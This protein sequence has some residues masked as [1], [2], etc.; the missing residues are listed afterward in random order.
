MSGSAQFLG[1]KLVSWSSKKQRSTAISTTEAE[2][3][4]MSGCCAQ[5]LWMRSH[6]TDYGF[7]FN[8]IPLY[9][10]NHEVEK[11]GVEL[12]FMTTD[13]QVADIFTKALPKERF[14]FLLPQLDTMADVN[15][16]EYAPAKQSHVV[17]PPTR[18]DDQILLSSNWVLIVKM[19][20]WHPLRFSLSTFGSFGTTCALTH[21]LGCTVVSWMR[22]GSIST[23]MFSKMLSI[24]LPPTN[25]NNPFVA[26]HLS[27]TV[28]EYVNT[29]GYPDTL[30]NVSVNDLYQPWRAI[31]SM[32]NM[33]NLATASRGKKK[34]THLLIPSIRF[35]G[36]DGREIFGMPIP[37]ALLTD[38]IKGAPYYDEYQEHEPAQPVVIKEPDSGRIQPLPDVQVKGKEKVF[39]E[40]AAHDLLTLQTPKNKSLVDQFIFQRRTPMPT[41]AFGP[42]ESPSLNAELALTDSEIEFDDVVPK[43]NTEDQDEGQTGPNPGIQD[44]GHAEPNPGVQDE[45]QAGSNHDL[46]ATDAS[47]LQNP[48][49]MDEEF[50]ITAYLNVQ[51]NLKLPFE[52]QLIL[53]EPASSTGT[54][55]SL[56][57][58][59][60]EL[61]FTYQFFIKKQQEEELGKTNAEAEVSKAVD[62]IVTNA[63]DWA[64]QA[65]L[66]AH[67]SD[68]PTVDIKE[69]LQQQMF[70]SKSYEAH[71][72]NKKLYDALKKSLERD[73]SYQLLSDLDEARQ[74]KRKRSNMPRTP[75]GSPSLQPPPPPPPAGE[76]GAPGTSR[77][78]G[79]SQ[80][81]P[82]PP[83]P[84]PSTGTSE[85]AQQQGSKALCSSK[86]AASALYFMAWTTSNTRYESANVS[87]TQELSPMDSLIQ[88]DSIPNEKIHFSNDKDSRN[89]HL[90]KADSRKDWWKPL[91]EEE[92]PAASYPDFGL[93]LLMPEQMWIE[94]VCTYDISAKYGICHW[95][96]NRQKFY[97][98]RHDS[99]SCQKEVR[100][101][102]RILSV[103]RIKA[104]SRYGY[105]YLSDIVL[106]RVDLQEHTIAE[107][108][109]KNLHP[110]DFEDL[111]LL[112]LD[113]MEAGFTTTLTAKLH[114]FNP[115][116]YDLWL[117]RIEQ[118]FLMNDYSLWEVIKNGN[119]VLKRTVGTVEQIYEP[120]SAEEKL[121]RKNEVKARGTLLMSLLNKDQLMF[122]SYQDA[123]LLMEAIEKRYG[124]NKE[125]KKVQRTLLKQQYENFVASSS[126]TL[127][128]IFDRLQK[129]I[130]QLEIQGQ[131]IEQED[132]NLKL[133]RSLPSKWKTRALIRRNKADIETI[134]NTTYGV[135]T[136]HTRGN[137][138][139]STS[140]DNLSDALICSFFA[141]QPKYPQLA[142]EDL[143]QIDH[144]NLNE[145]D[146]H[147]EMAMLI[148]KARRGYDW[149]YQAEEEH[150]TNYALMEL[151]SSGSSS[152]SDSK[153]DSCSGTCIKAFVTLKEQYD[154]LS[155]DY[156]K[157]MSNAFKR[158]H[159]QV[160]RPYN[161]YSVYKKT[162]FNKMVNTVRVKDTNAKERAVGNPQQKEYRKK[163]VIDRRCKQDETTR[164]L[165]EIDSHMTGNK[166]YLTEYEDYDGGFVSFGDG[167]GRISG[168]GKI[169]T[170]TMDFDDVYFCKELKYNMFS[171][172]QM[173][174]KKNN[175][176]FT[177]TE[178]LVL[179]FNFKL[180]DESKVL[181]RVPRKDNIYSVD[182]KSVVPTR[183]AARTMLVDSKLPTTFWAEVV[184]TA[185]Y[186][187]NRALVIKP[188]NKTPY[189]LIRG[190]PPLI[191]F[192][193]PFGCRV[194]ILNT[195]DHLGKFDGKADEGFFIGYFMV[196]KQTNG[197]VG[198]KDNIVAGQAKKKKELKQEY[199]LMPIC[200][201]DPLIS[202]GHKDSAVD[203]GKKATKV[204]RNKKDERGIV[205]K[206]KAR[207]V[208]Q[209]HT[210]EEGIDYDEVF[211][212]VARI[213]AIR[214][215]LACAFFKDFVVYQMDPPRAWYETLSTYLMDYGFY[216]GQIDKTLLFKRHKDDIL[217]VQVYVD[218]IIFG[219]T[220]KEL[221]TE[222]EK[223]MHDKFQM[224]SMGELSLFFGLQV[225]QKS[226][227]IFISQDKYV[228]NILKEFNFST[229]K[230]VS[231]LMEP[232]KALV[233]DTEAEDVDVNLYRLMI[234]SLMYLT[235]SRPHITFAICACARFQVTLKTSHLHDVKR[236]FR[237]L[238]GQRKLA[239][240]YP[241]DSPFELEDYFDSDYAGASLDRKSIIGKYVDAA[242]CCG[243][244]LWIQ[245]QMLDYVF[246]FLNTKIYIDIEST[247]CIVKNPV[248]HS[249]TKHIEIRR[250]LKLEDSDGIFTLLNPKI[251]EQLALMGQ[252]DQ[253]KDQLGVLSAA[254][255]LANATR[256]H[257]YSRRIRAVSTGSGRVS[258][259]SRIISTAEEIVSTAGVSMPVS[260]AGMDEEENQRIAKD[261]KIAQRLQEEIDAAKRQGMAQVHQAAQ[262]FIKDECEN[263]RARVEAD[264]ELTQRLQA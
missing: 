257:T 102:M 239:L 142:R 37:D 7:A 18:T 163:G 174:D 220:K 209:G 213:E 121:D 59:E 159:S 155:S 140:V 4:A 70:E 208:A 101:H 40:Q 132:R 251:F 148:I 33:E 176:L 49:Q 224:S 88:D 103:V 31:F 182:L 231:T 77:A 173:C 235:T 85:S 198:T 73:Y 42:A 161:K 14:E 15:I 90:T 170:G 184:N 255:I 46:E 98:D 69:I 218:D 206:N 150:P 48:E 183:E 245:N 192:M 28:I 115:K 237:Y 99:P 204:F 122:H 105:D 17:A 27:D 207:L 38:E 71:E 24:L 248:F 196:R 214:L 250:H 153:V 72:D 232:N 195:R 260:T 58:L 34:T 180:L 171:V 110:S 12:F 262:T 242:N 89:D 263:I 166:C 254:K 227:G 190:R 111:N 9:C 151:T 179:S 246:N 222:F 124:G 29:L 108:D 158:G 181:L 212:L 137:I 185:C 74:K 6:L 264:E 66:Q 57:N 60:K 211:A 126:E 41:E 200:T 63:V 152:S 202:Q 199:I 175:V 219:S 188:H 203:A 193:K 50:T 243:Q 100:S 80:M 53:E 197:I 135:S 23:R 97:I 249:K 236:I 35:V 87:K 252:E 76:S 3:I 131:V 91:P 225:Q 113:K 96:F 67:F 127:D 157:P 169:R 56:Q 8:K 147:W 79:S 52:D 43:I 116:E 194:T 83:L 10:D 39:N 20:S 205:V 221:S 145:I 172:S 44:E 104:Y 168:K 22:N 141:S 165:L 156:K 5:I 144:D 13:Y 154:S 143:E 191:D 233:K 125:S 138:V 11:G 86:S 241:R 253:P 238:K 51:E 16:P 21:L 2:Y 95:W 1:D 230:T 134:N 25:D 234:R 93:E 114:I 133:L 118:Y 256:V 78:S 68:L 119:K 107:K 210:Q 82:L 129:L 186:V 160:V 106:R 55:S 216:M 30:R 130:S 162:I 120:T 62:E 240:W 109:F 94:D 123:K 201:T 45:G 84:P 187:L 139:N 167:K 215:F 164:E 19:H 189:E 259:A 36:K 149:R 229:V 128:Q 228:A 177:D 47:P 75:S 223:L 217:L 117:M 244:V 65:S 54:L 226:D 32:I 261:A 64:M 146:L 112:L 136:G 247:I 258:T 81:P 178:C 61:S 26:P 92:R